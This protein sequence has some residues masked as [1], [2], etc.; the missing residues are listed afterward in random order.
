PYIQYAYVRANSILRKYN[1]PLPDSILP[2]GDLSASEIAL[3]DLIARMPG[4]I[5][6]AAKELKPLTISNLAYDLAKAF[7][8][9][10][11]QCP[12]LIAEEPVKSSRIRLVAAAKQAIAN[13]LAL[14]GITAPQ[15]M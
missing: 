11:G 8:D 1:A 15:A 14:L 13:S 7:N 10:Y 3:I 6:K 12:V 9:F 4:E 5:Q 2:A